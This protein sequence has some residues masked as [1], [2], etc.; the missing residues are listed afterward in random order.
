MRLSDDYFVGL[1]DGEGS[2][3]VRHMENVHGRRVSTSVQI[4]ITMRNHTIVS[5]FKERFGGHVYQDKKRN[6][7]QWSIGAI[8]G[9]EFLRLLCHRSTSK[10]RLAQIALGAIY[11]MKE[12]GAVRGRRPI[13]SKLVS[14]KNLIGRRRLHELALI[15][16]KS[17]YTGA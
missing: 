6:I 15:A 5:M 16:Q 9:E 8:H 14:D 10:R 7:W 2:I 1:F 4:N 17:Q 3:S 13:G 11:L 12:T